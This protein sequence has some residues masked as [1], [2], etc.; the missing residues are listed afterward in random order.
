[1]LRSVKDLRGYKILATDGE[2][3]KVHEFYFDDATWTIRYLVVNTGSW[4]FERRVL[5]SPIVLGQPYW[6]MRVFPVALTR[7]QVK[8]SPSIETDKPVSRQQEIEL[9]QY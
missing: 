4:L 7:M 5:L 3:G 9:H 8:N 2:I 6:Q 1:M